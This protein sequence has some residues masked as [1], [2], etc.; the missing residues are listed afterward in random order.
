M[1]LYFMYNTAFDNS[2]HT[3]TE[4]LTEKVQPYYPCLLLCFI[5]TSWHGW[6]PTIAWRYKCIL[7]NNILCLKY[8][9]SKHSA[10]VIYGSLLNILFSLSFCTLSL[11]KGI[12]TH[13]GSTT[14]DFTKFIILSF[15][16][17]SVMDISSSH[18]LSD[19]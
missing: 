12:K 10:K 6:H 18:S 2:N 4:N 3:Q 15:L 1:N 19:D 11:F 14:N 16:F 7:K 9:T 5:K 8:A 13:F 17:N